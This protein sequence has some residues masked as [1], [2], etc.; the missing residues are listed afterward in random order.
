MAVLYSYPIKSTPANRNDLV[1]I[2]DSRD[3]NKTKQIAVANLPGSASFTGIGGSGTVGYIPKFSTSTEVVDSTIYEQGSNIGIGTTSPGFKLDVAG[4]ARASY[5][6]L[7][8]NES[9]PAE[10]SF[11]YRPETGVIGFGTASTERMRITS[12]G[13]VGIGTVTPSEKL[14]VA[15]KIKVTGT[16]DFIT[17]VRNSAGQANYIKFYNTATSANEAYIGFTSNNKDLKFQNLDTIGTISLRTGSAVALRVTEA[18]R[19]GIGTTVPTDKLTVAGNIKTTAG[20]IST[21]SSGYSTLELGGPTGAYIDLKSPSTDDYDLRILTTGSGG[22]FWTGG[23]GHLMTLSDT[24]NVGISVTSPAAKLDITDT[25]NQTS[26]RVTNNEYNNYLI[27]K[28][29][30]DD[31]QKLGIKEFGS[32]GGLALVT[33]GTERLNVNNLGNVGIGT[34]DP[35]T[36]LHV[37]NGKI[38]VNGGG[39]NQIQLHRNPSTQS[40]YIEYYDTA[41]TSQEAFVGYTSNNKD[42]KIYNSGASGTISFLTSSGTAMNITN[43]RKIG[44]G[45][46][47][48][49]SILTVKA[50]TANVGIPVIKASVNGFANGYTLIGDNYT[51]GGSQFN[52]GVSYSGSNGVL[53]RG[54]KVSS[55]ASNVFLSSQD[56]Y[57]LYSQAFVLQNDGSFRFLNTSTSAN[58]PV[59]TAV[60]LS[61]RMRI[62]RDGKVG[63]GTTAPTARLHIQD[64]SGSTSEFKMSAASNVANYAYLKMTDNTVNTAKLTLGT[65]YGYSTDKDAITMVNGNVGIG[66]TNPSASGLEV[67]NGS[68]ISGGQTQIY[69]TGST[70][71]RS[72]LGLGDGAN[73]LVQ[74]IMTDHTQNMM[75]FHTQASTVANNERMRITSSG[76]VGIGTTSPTNKLTVG[77]IGSETSIACASTGFDS[78]KLGSLT[79][80]IAA[81]WY[82]VAQWTVAGARG[83]A[84]VDVC[85]TGGAFAPVTYSIDYFKSYTQTGTEHT[86]KLEQYGGGAFINKARIAFDGASTFVEVYKID[87]TTQGTMQTQ[88]HFNRLIGESGGSLPLLGTAASGSGS[89]LLKEVSF[90]PKGT[91]VETLRVEGG[92]LN[93]KNLPTSA[94]GLSAG[95]IW[96]NSGVL[97]IIS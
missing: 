41:T 69:I 80:P 33:G 68:S 76:N 24:G 14:E 3:G 75:S 23:F 81:G 85:L 28:R 59:D 44:I 52:L 48:P 93:L 18:G 6:A 34:T 66:T 2:S 77:T 65:T 94:T 11:I 30:T 4:N 58:T 19:V 25:V 13:L 82:R 32:N 92:N 8:S 46:A 10:A 54:V 86:L 45:T 16:N 91:S 22:S 17:T 60:S 39:A 74:H 51:T 35:Q 42:F 70:N 62:T 63:V 20:F 97:N 89:T 72:V 26:I 71:G 61:E 29:R 83:G 67:A 40:N 50:D 53:S 38:R 31:T 88:I 90:I 43:S 73:K 78:L 49:D 87:T 57:S 64:T 36:L 12:G 5:F 15:G 27:Q 96:N 7:R 47:I 1:I 55:T 37:Q 84:R 56:Q 79:F 21:V 9:L 95:D